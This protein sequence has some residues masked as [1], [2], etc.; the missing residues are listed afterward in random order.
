[1]T[2]IANGLFAQSPKQL[3]LPRDLSSAVPVFQLD[4]HPALADVT[5]ISFNSMQAQVAVI[6]E[7]Y[8]KGV[9]IATYGNPKFADR[10]VVDP[11]QGHLAL[12]DGQRF[13]ADSAEPY[14]VLIVQIG[15]AHV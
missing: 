3:A 1:M 2:M 6:A 9:A 14:E 12:S 8:R 5:S 11:R 7:P 4:D 13:T 10:V 15:R